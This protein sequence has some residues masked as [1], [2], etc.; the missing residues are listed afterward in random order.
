MIYFL[1]EAVNS[2]VQP[3]ESNLYYMSKIPN[4]LNLSRRIFQILIAT[5]IAGLIVLSIT[6]SGNNPLT[7]SLKEVESEYEA[8]AP[9]DEDIT[10]ILYFEPTHSSDAPV[11]TKVL[12]DFIFMYTKFV[13]RNLG[14]ELGH[15]FDSVLK[16][17]T[18]KLPGLDQI[19]EALADFFPTTAHSSELSSLLYQYLTAYGDKQLKATQVEL[20]L[21]KDQTITTFGETH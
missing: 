3:L 16:G 7:P 18:F 19:R 4:K 17:F 5:L 1:D 11:P 10:Y 14:A 20:H 6:L 15:G 9:V 21:E 12:D 13:E 8:K 2:D